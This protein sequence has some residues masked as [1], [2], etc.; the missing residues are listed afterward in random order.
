[1]RELITLK[2]MLPQVAKFIDNGAGS[3]NPQTVADRITE[4]CERL[5]VKADLPYTTWKCRIHVQGDMFPLP[6]EMETVVA[7]NFDNRPAHVNPATV[8]FMDAGPGECRSWMGT[9]IRDLVD[10][11]VFPTMYDIPSLDNP[12]G[13]VSDGLRIIAFSTAQRD[14]NL[15]VSV[16]G[17]DYLNAPMSASESAFVPMEEIPIIPWS[18]GREGVISTGEGGVKLTYSKNAYREVTQ[19]AKPKTAGHVSLYAIEP[20]TNR[21]FFLAK[22]HPDDTHPCWRRYKITNVRGLPYR[23]SNILVYGKASCP[24]LTRDDDVLPVQNRAA[25]KLMVQAIEFE[26]KQQLKNATEYEA[27]AIRVLMEWKSDYDGGGPKI[28]VIDHEMYISNAP[29]S[30][31]MSR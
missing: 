30:R 17:R 27:Q 16:G 14:A 28:N 12:M 15:K 29:L 1:M 19:W 22:A 23:P 8:E 26:A 2:D 10:D 18:G 20:E 4:A 11:G 13:H 6:R 21:M 7:A 3:C 9:G 24:R 5:I 31:Y 25:V